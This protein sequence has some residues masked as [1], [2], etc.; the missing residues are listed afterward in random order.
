MRSKY[1][2][3]ITNGW[4]GEPMFVWVYTA[5]SMRSA[6]DLHYRLSELFTDK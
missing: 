3:Y 1:I 2:E 5:M 4:E 6:E